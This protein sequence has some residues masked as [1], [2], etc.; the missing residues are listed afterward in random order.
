V[1]FKIKCKVQR[2]HQSF[3]LFLNASSL[4]G[5]SSED[6]NSGEAAD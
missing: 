6:E 3:K 2:K 1:Y 5:R 4:F